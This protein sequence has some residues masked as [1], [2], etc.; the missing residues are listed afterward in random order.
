MAGNNHSIMDHCSV[1]WTIDEAFSSRNA[2]NITLQRTLISESLNYAGHNTQFIQQGHHVEHGYAATIGGDYGSYHHN[3]LAHNQGR[4][5]SMSGG[6]SDGNYA[7]HHD[8]F[9]NVCYNWGGRATDGGT[10]QGQFVNN[11]Y[12]MGPATTLTYLITADIEG[13]GGGT[14]AYYV[15]G[16]IRENKN[17]T[18][19][20]DAKN[21]TLPLPAVERTSSRLDRIRR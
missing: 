21:E 6:L 2:K 8:M 13:T 1:G 19:T 4:N 5:W 10:H 3:L 15:N 20:T 14:Q 17:G 12:K 18:L 16:N 9:N 7:G 11:Y